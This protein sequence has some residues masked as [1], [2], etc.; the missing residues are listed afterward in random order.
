M[1]DIETAKAIARK[2]V[3]GITYPVDGDELI[4][5]EDKIL[6]KP[7]GWVF[8]YTSKRFYIDKD[9]TFALA[10][11][12]PILIDRQAGEVHVLGTARPL[13]DYLREWD[14]GANR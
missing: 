2:Y 5:L 13:E 4:L 14:E 6:E 11:N 9:E 12:A 7:Y 8:Y 10:G 1:I 3:G